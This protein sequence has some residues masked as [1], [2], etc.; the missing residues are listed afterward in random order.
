MFRKKQSYS[1]FN[2]EER[3]TSFEESK[4]SLDRTS[5][6]IRPHSMLTLSRFHVKCQNE[7]VKKLKNKT[8]NK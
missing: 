3:K 4:T 6:Y 7:K 8:N 1:A 5:D 2:L